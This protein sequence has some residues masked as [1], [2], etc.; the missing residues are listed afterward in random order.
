M[1]RVI[2]PCA[3]QGLTAC[4]AAKPDTRSGFS[5]SSKGS[6]V[7]LFHRMTLQTN[8]DSAYIDKLRFPHLIFVSFAVLF[9]HY[10]TVKIFPYIAEDWMGCG[11]LHLLWCRT[12]K[13]YLAGSNPGRGSLISLRPKCNVN[14]LVL[15]FRRTCKNPT[16]SKLFRSALWRRAWQSYRWYGMLNSRNL[17]QM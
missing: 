1:T 13:K 5:L 3:Y 6:P 12:Y 4:A 14:T 7:A 8:T 10:I 2:A 9:I 16:L 15:R 17:F 11:F